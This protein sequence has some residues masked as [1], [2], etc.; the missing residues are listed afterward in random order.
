MAR[1]LEETR[2]LAERNRRSDVVDIASPLESGTYLVAQ[3]GSR[4]VINGH[5]MT[6]DTSVPRFAAWRGQSMGLDRV[7]LNGFGLR[8]NGLQPSDPT[9]YFAF[10]TKVSAPCNGRVVQ[11]VDGI[12]DMTVPQ[13]DRAN[14][15]GNYVILNCGDF[16]VIMAHFRNGSLEVSENAQVV[17]G[18]HLGE[19]GDSGDSGEPHLH[20]HAQK[21]LPEN[22]P[23]SGQPLPLTLNG[24]FYARNDRIHVK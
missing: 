24:H 13:M 6:L 12:A 5:L 9:Q 23:I 22:E 11:A 19:I 2:S 17:T 14:M 16:F 20:I 1:F 18:T 4:Q 10:G 15:L 21:D 8:A 3:G 7:R